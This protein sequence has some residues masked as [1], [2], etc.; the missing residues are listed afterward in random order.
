MLHAVMQQPH[1]VAIVWHT[2]SCGVQSFNWHAFL[3]WSCDTHHWTGWVIAANSEESVWYAVQVRVGSTL[4]AIAHKGWGT[5]TVVLP[6]NVVDTVLNSLAVVL[7]S[8][9]RVGK[10]AAQVPNLHVALNTWPTHK[11]SL[12]GRERKEH[13]DGTIKNLRNAI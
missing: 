11:A 2:K 7:S 1:H 5:L 8:G 10:L 12:E 4:L 13:E 6:N 3:W 9:T